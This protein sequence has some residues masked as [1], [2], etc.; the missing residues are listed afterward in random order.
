MK[1][2]TTIMR[3]ISPVAAKEYVAWLPSMLA[4][5]SA[6]SHS[7]SNALYI[8]DGDHAEGELLMRAYHRTAD[9][10]REFIG[11]GRLRSTVYHK[12]EGIWKFSYRSL[13][14]DFQ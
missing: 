3:R 8:V 12:R 1:T 9:N 5:W 4:H 11:Y 6:T 14:L 10:K 2:A 7:I 13:V